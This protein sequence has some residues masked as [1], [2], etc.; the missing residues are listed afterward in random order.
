MPNW[1]FVIFGNTLSLNVIFPAMILA[2]ALLTLVALY[3]WIEK[4]ATGATGEHHLLD[5]PRNAPVRTALGAAMVAFYVVLMIGGG[6]D[7]IAYNFDLS[8]NTM[9]RVLQV[10]L[11]VVPVITFLVTK[12][13]ALSLQRR[14]RDLL[15]HGRET[16][17]ILRLPSGEFLEI[18]EPV[19]EETRAKIMAKTD[20]EPLALPEGVDE[21]GVANPKA[22][23]GRGRARWS[24]FYYKDNV[25]L[26]S[27]EELASAQHHIA[28]ELQDAVSAGSEAAREIEQHQPN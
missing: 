19:D 15:L 5:R 28:H 6:N 3:P 9:I 24:R 7:V 4:R 22:R 23:R 1:E 14:D 25:P 20:I 2:P 27:E 16:G 26:P 18:H 10:S 12:R 21:H 8:I 13:I 11:F 17:R